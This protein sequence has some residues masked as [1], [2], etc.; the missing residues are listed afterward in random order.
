MDVKTLKYTQELFQ[1]KRAYE[2]DLEDV[3]YKINERAKNCNHFPVIVTKGANPSAWCLECGIKLGT[4]KHEIVPDA[5][6]YKEEKYGEGYSEPKKVARL[7]D[8]R[9]YASNWLNENADANAVEFKQA[10]VN[11]VKK[12][13]RLD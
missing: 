3:K 1:R 7:N 9:A 6:E 5:S 2:K 8:L 12:T 13:K 4:I 11:E 10:I